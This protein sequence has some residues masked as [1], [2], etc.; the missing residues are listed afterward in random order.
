MGFSDENN[1]AIF[2][3]E[4]IVITTKDFDTDIMT[5]ALTHGL[6]T[7]VEDAMIEYQTEVNNV[8]NGLADGSISLWKLMAYFEAAIGKTFDVSG[9]AD[10]SDVE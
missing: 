6:N 7:S 5:Y 2:S 9:D 8:S 1:N 3:D 4:Q 10:F